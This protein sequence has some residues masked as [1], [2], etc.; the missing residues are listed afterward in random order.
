M[1][2]EYTLAHNACLFTEGYVKRANL[3]CVGVVATC[4]IVSTEH[5]HLETVCFMSSGI[6]HNEA[7]RGS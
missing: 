4:K 3:Q 1:N 2:V 6:D 7:L 5:V